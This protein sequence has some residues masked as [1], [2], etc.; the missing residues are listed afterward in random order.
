MDGQDVRGESTCLERGCR[1]HRLGQLHLQLF[2]FFLVHPARAF[3]HVFRHLSR[4]FI[5]R[6]DRRYLNDPAVNADRKQERAPVEYRSTLSL[7][8]LGDRSLVHR[9]AA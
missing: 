4:D 7:K 3:L 6:S 2:V 5:P 8:L 1:R 9:L